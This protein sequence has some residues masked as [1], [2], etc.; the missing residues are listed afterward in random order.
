MF[1]NLF[2]DKTAIKKACKTN[3]HFLSEKE[4][5][6]RMKVIQ[7]ESERF[8]GRASKNYREE[9]LAGKKE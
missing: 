9:W 3:F 1:L 4:L 7:C 8:R 2:A 5:D 6:E